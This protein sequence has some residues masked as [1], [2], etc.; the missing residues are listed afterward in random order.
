MKYLG[1]NIKNDVKNL[2]TE[3]HK[4]L[5]K[6]LRKKHNRM[7]RYFVFMDWKNRCS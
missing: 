7:E 3:R 4:A 2:Y 5:L 6:R 1:I